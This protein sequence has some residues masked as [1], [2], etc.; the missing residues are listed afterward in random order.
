M[1]GAPSEASSS[2]QHPGSLESIASL[3]ATATPDSSTD[4]AAEGPSRHLSAT[5]CIET[6][7]LKQPEDRSSQIKPADGEIRTG[8]HSAE[9][10]VGVA[11]VAPV[12]DAQG[13]A[14]MTDSSST[15]HVSTSVAGG[16]QHP[17]IQALDH[18][19]HLHSTADTTHSDSHRNA[20]AATNS[21]ESTQ[22]AQ[23]NST[24]ACQTNNSCANE[25]AAGCS[26][27]AN[28]CSPAVPV[29][30]FAQSVIPTGSTVQP[31]EASSNS[32][33]APAAPNPW[34]DPSECSQTTTH[35]QICSQSNLSTDSSSGC[36]PHVLAANPWTSSTHPMPDATATGQGSGSSTCLNH[37][38]GCKPQR[39]S[40][41]SAGDGEGWELV[42]RNVPAVGMAA[43]DMEAV[44]TVRSLVR[45]L[46]QNG[47][48]G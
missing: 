21:A 14:R 32:S 28:S 4:L 20:Q 11:T 34:P 27:S 18:S 40:G 17:S 30:F 1:E 9:E 5:T 48:H 46:S 26:S 33:P 6:C 38:D 42:S 35:G 24:D 8:Q 16:E 12:N 29:S 25:D 43:G 47:E 2:L 7:G 45:G 41:E 22:V 15:T 44:E 23:T 39:L 31:M 36:E 13:V 3:S 37:D 10:P 19:P